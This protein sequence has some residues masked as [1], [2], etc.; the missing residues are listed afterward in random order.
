MVN[1]IYSPFDNLHGIFFMYF[2]KNMD[3]IFSLPHL[4]KGQTTHHSSPLH[5][6][7]ILSKK[8]YILG[9]Y[10]YWDLN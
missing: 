9:Q 6:Y 1:S 5:V 2:G 10:I 7:Y 3:T 8:L 4:L